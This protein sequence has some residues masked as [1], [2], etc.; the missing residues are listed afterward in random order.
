MAESI[1][2]RKSVGGSSGASK[3][4]PGTAKYRKGLQQRR[5]QNLLWEFSGDPGELKEDV[6]PNPAQLGE[7]EGRILKNNGNIQSSRW[8]VGGN[9]W[10]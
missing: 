10:W 3:N 7:L 2:Q 4:S 5:N 6:E 9:W 8:I 1:L